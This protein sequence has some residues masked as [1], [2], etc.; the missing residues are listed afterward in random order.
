LLGLPGELVAQRAPGLAPSFG[1]HHVLLALLVLGRV[2]SMGRMRLGRELGLGEGAVRNLLSRLR[3]QGLV[4]ADRSGCRLAEKGLKLY[5]RL[6]RRLVGPHPVR[7][8]KLALDKHACAL[9]IR[10]GASRVKLGLE[11]RDEGIKVGGSGV[12]TL[13][14]AGGKFRIPGGS[15]DCERDYGGPEWEELRRRLGPREG[16]AIVVASAPSEER[17]RLAAVAAGASL[18][19]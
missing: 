14:Y 4:A 10:G 9:L 6:R 7:A 8:G 17:A 1:Q 19:R 2:G 5:R 11:Q 13:I 18:L 15:E 16:D 3:G 12:V